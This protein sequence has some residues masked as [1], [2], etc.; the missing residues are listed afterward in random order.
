VKIGRL[1]KDEKLRN[2][3][4]SD[5]TREGSRKGNTFKMTTVRGI[6]VAGKTNNTPDPHYPKGH[7]CAQLSFKNVD[8]GSN[9]H[10]L[11]HEIRHGTIAR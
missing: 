6:D 5:S 9:C 1:I 8:T 3:F 10:Y 4:A 7:S 2:A 11:E